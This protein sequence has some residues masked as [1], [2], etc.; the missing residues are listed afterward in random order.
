[1]AEILRTRIFSSS[2]QAQAFSAWPMLARIQMAASSSCVQQPAPGWMESMV[3]GMPESWNPGIASTL[4]TAACL[5][6]IASKLIAKSTHDTQ[7]ILCLGALLLAQQQYREFN[8]GLANM[9]F[10]RHR[11]CCTRADMKCAS[12]QQ[13]YCEF[14]WG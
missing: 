14:H 3:S 9:G 4:C 2:I 7:L 8:W 6:C 5:S 12:T 10:K 1:M 11:V 13:Q